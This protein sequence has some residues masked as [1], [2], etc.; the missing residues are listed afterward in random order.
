MGILK[1]DFGERATVSELLSEFY[2]T[3]QTRSQSLQDF[4]VELMGKL[5]RIL[6]V[7]R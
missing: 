7:D 5:D 3:K 2:S 1:E 6:R 4:S